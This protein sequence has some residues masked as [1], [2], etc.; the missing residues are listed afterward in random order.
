MLDEIIK[1]LGEFEYFYDVNGRFIFQRK[2]IYYNSSWNN[3]I[4][5]ENQTYYDS[6]ANS[7]ASVYNFQS[8]YLVN[9][10]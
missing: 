4:T 8:G 5:Y 3:A 7:S 1:M 10:F 2:K 6:V 9:S